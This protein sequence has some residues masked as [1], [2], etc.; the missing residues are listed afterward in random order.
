[1]PTEYDVLIGLE[2][3]AELSTHSKMFCECKNPSADL[4][5]VPN[6]TICPICVGHPGTLPSLNWK[7]I[8]YTVRTGLALGS[9]IA[10]HSKFDRKHYFYPDLPK[11][12]Q[13]SQY[14]MPL[15]VGGHIQVGG[16]DIDIIRV[17]I[18]EDTGKLIH[19]QG[20][21][22]VDYNRSGVPLM[23]LVSSPMLHDGRE[24]REF[25]EQYRAIIR[26]LGVSDADMEKGQMRVEANISLQSHGSWR[27]THDYKIQAVEGATLNPKIEVKNLNSFKSVEGAISYEIARQKRALEQGEHLVQETRGWD[28]GGMKTKSQRVKEEA[29][30]YRYFPEPDLPP[31]TLSEEYIEDLKSKIPELPLEKVARFVREYSIPEVTAR[32]IVA[33]DHLGTIFEEVMSEIGAW[34]ITS[35]ENT[36]EGNARLGKMAS[37]WLVNNAAGV[38][39]KINRGWS[40]FG[41]TSEDFAEFI[42][43]L[44]MGTM[45]STIGKVVLE[46]MIETHKDP[47]YILEEGG[48]KNTQSLDV[49][50][51][52][53][54]VLEQHAKEVTHYKEGKKVVAQFFVGQVMKLAKGQADP[55]EILRLII[56]ELGD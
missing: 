32:T 48:L 43:L 39:A 14:D 41:V 9:T 50:T 37:N 12:Y 53:R 56:D 8:E 29:M 2:I 20:A 38:L 45:N 16:R 18:E 33:T 31:L 30:D 13:L 10:R 55:E 19:E 36:E 24:A 35:G 51:I 6:S 49:S 27:M 21:S 17:H 52:V 11:G 15:C 42:H 54:Q 26:T 7:G 25:A 34:A 44:A 1:M 3:H 22:L 5:T 47:H 40:E 46:K 23:E 28:E 4:G